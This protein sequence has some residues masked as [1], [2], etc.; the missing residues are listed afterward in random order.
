MNKCNVSVITNYGKE[1]KEQLS[2]EPCDA[3]RII[4]KL[5]NQYYNPNKIIKTVNG[6]EYFTRNKDVIISV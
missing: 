3:I 1:Y 2:C 4:C 5:Q 6:Y